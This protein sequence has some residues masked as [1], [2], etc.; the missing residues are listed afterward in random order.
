MKGNKK[1]ICLACSLALLMCFGVV[2]C[3]NNKDNKTSQ[4]E[5]QQQVS[6]ATSNGQT[7]VDYKTMTP[8]KQSDF[9]SYKKKIEKQFEPLAN[10]KKLYYAYETNMAID[11]DDNVYMFM[12]E[13]SNF[14]PA[15]YEKV[16]WEVPDDAKAE[17][18]GVLYYR[19]GADKNDY[20]GDSY[21]YMLENDIKTLQEIK[22]KQK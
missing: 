9:E 18:G 14:K 10:G 7:V 3:G 1:K 8:I 12:D 15:K 5:S 6:D 19:I 20:E 4:K 2:G 11:D 21:A 17:E 13:N 16:T 22:N